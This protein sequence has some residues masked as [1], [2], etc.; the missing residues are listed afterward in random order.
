MIKAFDE[1]S[2]AAP[3]L[4]DNTLDKLFEAQWDKMLTIIVP[5]IVARMTAI[6]DYKLNAPPQEVN[7]PTP[8]ADAFEAR[9]D[10]NTITIPGLE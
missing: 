8:P 7:I 10:T 4:I 3:T 1:V 2:D 9:S 5:E 6:I